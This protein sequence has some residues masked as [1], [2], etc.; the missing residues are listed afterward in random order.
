MCTEH[1]TFRKGLSVKTWNVIWKG[2][3]VCM[4]STLSR[5]IN[6]AKTKEINLASNNIAGS[7]FHTCCKGGNI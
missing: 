7:D 1:G 3:I 5:R 4:P 6:E 2:L